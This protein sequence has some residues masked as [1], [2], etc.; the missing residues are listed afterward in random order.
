MNKVAMAMYLADVRLTVM[1]NAPSSGRHWVTD[2]ILTSFILRYFKRDVEVEA[3]AHSLV[4][5]YRAVEH[6]MGEEEAVGK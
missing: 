3:L 6:E 1:D 4:D 5:A 2:D